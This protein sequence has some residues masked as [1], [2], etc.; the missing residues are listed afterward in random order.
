MKRWLT[1]LD[2][3]DRAALALIVA[4]LLASGIVALR[5]DRVGVRVLSFAPAGGAEGVS[6]RA[7]VRITF[8]GLMEQA[9]VEPLLRVEPETPGDLKWQGDTLIFRPD[10]GWAA[11]THYTVTLSAGAR[12]AQGRRSLDDLIWRFRTGRPRLLY[13]H[14]RS[15][16]RSRRSLDLGNWQLFVLSPGAGE[17]VQ[18]TAA[19]WG[20]FDYDVSADGTQIVYSALREDGG[21]D[22]WVM[23]TD[24]SDQRPLLECPEAKCAAP[25]W[26]PDDRRIAYE[27]RELESSIEGLGVGPGAPRVWLLDP[28]NGETVPLFEDGQMLGYAPRWA[29]EGARLAYFDSREFGVRVYNLDDGTSLLIPSQSGLAGTWSPAGDRIL[30]TDMVVLGGEIASHLWLASL[31]GGALANVSGGDPATGSGHHDALVQDGWPSWSP[32]GEWMAFTRRALTG[33]HATVGQQPWLMRPDGS[34]A[35]PL[36]VDPAARFSHVAW[37]PDGRALAYVRLALGDP[38][39][40]PELWLVELPAGEP[41]LLAEVSTAPTWLP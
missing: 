39:A 33:E 20:V 21:A 37:R 38:H 13:L 14:D 27:Q 34:D 12:S 15:A 16:E 31:D 26:S 41:V 4:F 11:D 19:P 7:P 24:G 22:L 10:E 36:L 18:L 32:S 23:N 1:D 6:T 29:P 35:R 8:A 30:V 40:R 25:T 28:A 9:S 3:F 5:G 17:P 2:R